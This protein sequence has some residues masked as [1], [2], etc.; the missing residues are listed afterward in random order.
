MNL[1]YFT[2]SEFDSPDL[3]NSGVNM[4]EQFLAKLEQAREIASIPF[5]I[6]SGYRTK[7]YNQSLRDKGYKASTNSSHLIGVA[8]DIAVSGGN[9]RY[10]ILSALIKAGFRRIGVAKT[11]IHCDIDD[12]KPNSVWTY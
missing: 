8:A 10:I 1:N 3:P 2:L 11:F 7:E 12:S 6:T 9:D 5:R 4:D